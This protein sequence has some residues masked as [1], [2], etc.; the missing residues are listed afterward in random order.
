[1]Q[2]TPRILL[3]V[4]RQTIKH[5]DGMWSKGSGVQL[6]LRSGGQQRK[7]HQRR[8]IHW[9][10]IVGKSFILVECQKRILKIIFRQYKNFLKELAISPLVGICEQSPGQECFKRIRSFVRWLDQRNLQDHIDSK[11]LCC[12]QRSYPAARLMFWGHTL[13]QAPSLKEEY[14]RPGSRYKE[15]MGKT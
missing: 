2:V 10:F 14:C 15:L 7:I 13:H 11:S 4:L 3:C 12:L 6:S 5:P 8:R 9:S 1:M